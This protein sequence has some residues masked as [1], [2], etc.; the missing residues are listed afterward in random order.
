MRSASDRDCIMTSGNSARDRALRYAAPHQREY[1]P[2]ALG[3]RPVF[4]LDGVVRPMRAKW[5]MMVQCP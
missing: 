1:L 4:N 2:P 5:N 3:Q